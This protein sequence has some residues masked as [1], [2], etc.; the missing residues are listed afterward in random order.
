MCYILQSHLILIESEALKDWRTNKCF[1]TL[2]AGG[3]Q[4]QDQTV[5]GWNDSRMEPFT[6]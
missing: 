5:P 1:N 3:R 6:E 2:K 4:E